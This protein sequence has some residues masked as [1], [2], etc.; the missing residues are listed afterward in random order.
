MFALESRRLPLRSGRWDRELRALDPERDAEEIA[1]ILANHVFPLEFLFSLELAQFRTFTIPSIS[2]ILHS[3]GQYESEGQ[4]RLDDTRA[5]LTEIHRPGL[6]SPGSREM[7]RHLNR[8]HA[9]YPISNDDYLYTLS[10]FVF[11]PP[12]FVE[13]WG[14]RPFTEAEKD[15]LHALYRKLGAAMHIDGVPRSRSAFLAWRRAYESRAQR[16][17]PENE[18]VARG[19]LRALAAPL[20]PAARPAFESMTVALLE[21]GVRTALG[22]EEPS[23]GTEV[24][25]AALRRVYRRGSRRLAFFEH[26]EF[27]ETAF[28]NFYATYPNGYHRL[29]L[30]PAKVLAF[31]ER[32]RRQTSH[33]AA[34]K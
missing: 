3:T 32:E 34:L 18:A 19:M 12:A 22:F 15:A 14:H 13:R 24:A 1:R 2:R 21:P 4:K 5:I 23:V 33:E 9:L 28:A 17:A 29:K 20:P 7:V 31:L 10:T 11:D 16:Y 6:D 26:R 27:G 8:I 25:A 30:G